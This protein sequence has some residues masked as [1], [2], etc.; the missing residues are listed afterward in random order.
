MR[1]LTRPA[2]SALA[3]LCL[4]AL[5]APASQAATLAFC[6][7]GGPGNTSQAEPKVAQFLRHIERTVGLSA[8]S[9]SGEYHTDHA[10]C[11]RYFDAK[12]PE[13]GVLDLATLLRH[14][15]AWKLT[16]IAHVGEPAPTRYHVLVR[17]GTY[18]ALGAL[19]GKQVIAALP[20]DS[21]FLSKIVLDGKG[22]PASWK[23][24]FTSRP[25][26][27]LRAVAREEADA[28]IVDGETFAHL[29]ELS[30]PTA[31][32]S[33][34]ESPALPGLTMVSV[35]QNGGAPDLVARLLKALGSLCEGD[36]K[37]LCKQ[38]KVDRLQ[39]AEPARFEALRRSYGK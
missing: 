27:G 37:E 33:I 12:R 6:H 3:T 22:D 35:G 1:H 30:L 39:K 29:A 10:G 36:G 8:G 5:A 24:S 28:T 38:L 20:D 32:V 16:P 21:D 4:V 25:L 14:G 2:L 18:A 19:T 17:K 15:A 13:I 11:V 9:L 7:D 23:V 31:L 34:H 26:K